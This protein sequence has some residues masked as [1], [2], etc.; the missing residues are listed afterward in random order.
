MAL[1]NQLAIR[2]FQTTKGKELLDKK[3]FTEIQDVKHFFKKGCHSP[4]CQDYIAQFRL[5]SRLVSI[6]SL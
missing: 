4:G 1:V 3:D 5:I 2:S 6:R